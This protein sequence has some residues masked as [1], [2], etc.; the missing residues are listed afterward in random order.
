M[1]NP[2]DPWT[3]RALPPATSVLFT[4]DG[5]VPRL[6][7]KS[8]MQATQARQRGCNHWGYFSALRTCEKGMLGIYIYIYNYIYTIYIYTCYIY[9]HLLNKV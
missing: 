9:M 2:G 5:S 7:S 4:V 8:T 1:I 3:A 6:G